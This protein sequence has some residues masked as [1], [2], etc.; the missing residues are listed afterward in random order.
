MNNAGLKWYRS[1]KE[2]RRGFCQESGASI[3][4][5]YLGVNTIS[6]AADMQDIAHV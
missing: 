2:A 4:W 5:E 6:I 3:F 1:S